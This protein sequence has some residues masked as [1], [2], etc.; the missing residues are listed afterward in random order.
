MIARLVVGWLL[1]LLVIELVAIAW[2]RRQARRHAA[3]MARLDQA[4]ADQL[5]LLRT[6]PRRLEDGEIIDTL[7]RETGGNPTSYEEDLESW[8]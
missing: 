8:I 5:R 4:I 6:P 2:E 3:A 7:I 1:M